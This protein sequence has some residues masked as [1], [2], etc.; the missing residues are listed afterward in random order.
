[1]AAS[2]HLDSWVE[3]LNASSLPVF[4]QTVREVSNV[5]SSRASSAQ[6]LSYV[7]SRDAAMTARL[8]QIANSAMFNLQNRRIDTISAAVVM[9]GFDAV[10]ELAVSVSVLDQMLQGNPHERVSRTMA[11]AFH[12]AAH[13]NA[14]AQFKQSGASEEVFVGA[15]LREVGCMAFWCKGG[16]VAEQMH[17][18]LSQGQSSAEVERDLLGFSLVDLNVRLSELWSLG[19]LVVQSH[20]PRL[21]DAPGV[22]CVVA[23]HEIATAL[24]VHGWESPECKDVLLKIAKQFDIDPKQMTE[25]ARINVEEAQALADNFGLVLDA[26]PVEPQAPETDVSIDIGPEADDHSNA[27]AQ[28]DC[29]SQI[30]LG[31]EEQHPRD[32]LMALVV[33]GVTASLG[34]TRTLFALCTPNQRGLVV[35]YDSADNGSIVGEQLALDTPHPVTDALTQRK[36]CVTRAP[37]NPPWISDKQQLALGIFVGSRAVGVLFAQGAKLDTE[38]HVSTFRQFAQQIPLVLTQTS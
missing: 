35:K 26:P 1:M 16:E 12:A 29:L 31:I 25:Q 17:L 37:L 21:S 11:R 15:L 38:V 7:V 24:E 19:D 34:G 18:R 22:S 20:N 9:M 8:I 2:S 28:L 14:L 13:A 5:A 33:R 30:A 3:R 36:P 4:A 27:Q 6:D 32:D 10:K 23:G